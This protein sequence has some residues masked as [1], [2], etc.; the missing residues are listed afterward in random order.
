MGRSRSPRN[1]SRSPSRDRPR[2][3]SRGTLRDR[4]R[5]RQK[6]S[7]GSRRSSPRREYKD[8]RVEAKLKKFNDRRQEDIEDSKIEWGH[9][10]SS[11]KHEPNQDMHPSRVARLEEMKSGP[12]IRYAD[13]AR[14]NQSL[15]KEVR[16]DDPARSFVE[17]LKPTV[18]KFRYQ[19]NRFGIAPG[20][21]WDGIDRSNGFEEKWYKAKAQKKEKVELGHQYDV[22]N[23]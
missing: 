16:W 15:K 17:E 3:I 23:Y 2:N 14:L 11:S 8:D 22:A 5:D 10:S 20:K 6:D 4:S 13:D 12:F 1:R 21:G 18:Q 9:S 19:P 7:S